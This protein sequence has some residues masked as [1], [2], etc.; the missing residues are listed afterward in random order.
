MNYL[1]LGIFAL[2]AISLY[3]LFRT[4]PKKKTPFPVDWRLIL[5]D[6]V[7]FYKELDVT[8]KERFE[9]DILDFLAE[10]DI[11]GIE[12]EVT[13]TDRILVG[14]SAVIPLFGYPGWRYRNLNEVLL[15]NSTFDHDYETK[16]RER[17]ILGMVGEGAMNRM[18]ILSKPA[19]HEGFEN[20]KS[21]TNVGIHEFV[22]LLDKADGTINGIPDILMKNQ[23]SIP[24][25]KLMMDEIREIK[26]HDSDVNPYGATNEAEFLSVISEYFFKRP[27]LLKKKH[28]ELFSLLESMY[29]QDLA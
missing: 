8:S 1:I 15:Y 9:Q 14:A 12:T 5:N 28:P 21:K 19:L 23:F 25:V 18:M 26:E 20:K 27:D 13:D 29:N 2:L 11:T 24:W 22:H 4:K 6:K 16:G 7:D 17:N 3:F 10:I